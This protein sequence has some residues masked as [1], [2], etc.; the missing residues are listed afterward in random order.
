MPL[1]EPGRLAPS[2]AAP[3]HDRFRHLGLDG[4]ACTDATQ[5]NNGSTDQY[6]HLQRRRRRFPNT[7]GLVPNRIND[8]KCALRKMVQAFGEVDFGLAS[9][10]LQ[11]NCSGAAA[12]CGPYS[13]V[14]GLGADERTG[15]GDRCILKTGGGSGISCPN[16]KETG[17]QILLVGFPVGGRS[18]GQGHRLHR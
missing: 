7:C 14:D 8:G 15:P 9:F 4:H 10:P 18:G 2:G 3:V 1:A 12:A 16:T 13:N 11:N 17:G 6:L 5:T